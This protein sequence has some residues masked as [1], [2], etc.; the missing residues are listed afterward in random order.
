MYK[1][2]KNIWQNYINYNFNQN[3]TTPTDKIV[4]NINTNTI[5]NNPKITERKFEKALETSSNIFENTPSPTKPVRTDKTL[6]IK[7]K[8][9]IVMTGI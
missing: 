5:K 2:T 7:D 8:T 1:L 4:K 3:K 9:I 6:N